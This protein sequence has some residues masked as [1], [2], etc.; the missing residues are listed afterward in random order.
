[1]GVGNPAEETYC[2]PNTLNVVHTFLLCQ[3]VIIAAELP[4]TIVS[5]WNNG[6]LECCCF[7]HF[8][9]LDFEFVSDFEFRISDLV[10][11]ILRLQSGGSGSMLDATDLQAPQL[12]G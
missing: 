5:G 6:V 10:R 9:P 2:H 8:P 1:V 4:G 7:E 11:A 12:R 3:P